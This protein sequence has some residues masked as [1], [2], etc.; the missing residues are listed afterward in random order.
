MRG[1]R[2]RSSSSRGVRARSRQRIRLARE[3]TLTSV[4]V[5]WVSSDAIDAQPASSVAFQEGFRPA[6]GRAC[7]RPCGMECALF[8]L[9]GALLPRRL[10]WPFVALRD[11]G[12][13]APRRAGVFSQCDAKRSQLALR[14]VDWPLVLCV[15]AKSACTKLLGLGRIFRSDR[16]TIGNLTVEEC[17]GEQPRLSTDGL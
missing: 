9:G 6:T 17:R 14:F 1:N 15:D 2:V 13:L 16:S 3:Q 11:L 12:C 8:N 4:S 5:D 7:L 10:L